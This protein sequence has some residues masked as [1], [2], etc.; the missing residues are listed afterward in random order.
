MDD[1]DVLSWRLDGITKNYFAKMNGTCR[2]VASCGPRK[3]KK[4]GIWAPRDGGV[5]QWSQIQSPVSSRVE[6]L[7]PSFPLKF[8]QLSIL[9]RSVKRLPDIC[10]RSAFGLI[11]M[12]KAQYKSGNLPI[13]FYRKVQRR[14]T[15][16]SWWSAL[17]SHILAS[18][19]SYFASR[20]VQIGLVSLGSWKNWIAMGSKSP[21][22]VT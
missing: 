14:H 13:S 1:N 2:D 16:W 21:D 12:E 5:A 22:V 6:Y 18:S 20:G 7:W 11:H 4:K 17:R 19:Q 3:G 10:F 15:W 8:T 9:P